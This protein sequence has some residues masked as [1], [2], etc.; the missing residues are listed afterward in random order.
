MA[1]LSPSVA[2]PVLPDESRP[3]TIVGWLDR[4]TVLVAAG[5]CDEPLDLSA[6]DV[7]DGSVVALVEGVEVA[8]SRAPA[9]PGPDEVPEPPQA[10]PPPP[11]EGVG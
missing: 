1:N 8:A 11:P 2:N 4:T 6:V 7:L 3:T 5:G 10:P 9:P